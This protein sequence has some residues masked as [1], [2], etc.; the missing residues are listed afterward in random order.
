[1]EIT[2]EGNPI[3]TYYYSSNDGLSY[4]ESSSNTYIFNNLEK[5][6]EYNFKVYAVDTNGINSNINTLSE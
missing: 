1:M 6:T 4:E 2:T 5:G 3:A